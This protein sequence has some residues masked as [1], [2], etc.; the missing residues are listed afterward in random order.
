MA[1]LIKKAE[2]SYPAELLRGVAA[3][4]QK[5][6]GIAVLQ[7]GGTLFHLE[8][9]VGQDDTEPLTFEEFSETL[10]PFVKTAMLTAIGT[11]PIEDSDLQ[12]FS[13]LGTVENSTLLAM[14]DGPFDK[15][16]MVGKSNHRQFVDAFLRPKMERLFK[17]CGEDLPKFLNELRDED[18]DL[19][20]QE[21]CEPGGTI[22]LLAKTG[23]PFYFTKNPEA[24]K[25]DWGFSTS[26]LGMTAESKPEEKPLSKIAQMKAALMAKGTGPQPEVKPAEKPVETPAVGDPKPSEEPGKKTQVDAIAQLEANKLTDADKTWVRPK[27][28]MKPNKV[29]DMYSRLVQHAGIK[30]F[31]GDMKTWP[32][33][34]VTKNF[35][36]VNHTKLVQ[37]AAPGAEQKYQPFQQE[38][39]KT[40]IGDALK[41]AQEATKPAEKE[42]PKS[43]LMTIPVLSPESLKRLTEIK[44]TL[45]PAITDEELQKLEK[46]H[47]NFFNL[48]YSYEELEKMP[49]TNLEM[50]CE[51]PKAGAVLAW[52][53]LNKARELTRVLGK[54]LPEHIADVMKNRHVA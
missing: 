32:P 17:K 6:W 29:R 30:P 41:K 27:A 51:D 19:Q 39:P 21:Q 23:E 15:W 40:A 24:K 52:T 35:Y 14:I 36:N 16:K 13:L 46:K 20:M 45:Q 48:G 7:K 3:I 54:K 34:Q 1:I 11:T 50:I 22:A 43:V 10:K 2:K 38:E 26:L 8:G 18:F 44:K 28:D 33:V 42:K 53:L 12:P 31:T 5:W 9:V 4:D 49:F 25:H 47:S 37:V